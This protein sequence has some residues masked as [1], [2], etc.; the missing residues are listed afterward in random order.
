MPLLDMNLEVYK[1][2]SPESQKKVDCLYRIAI[3][4][5]KAN[6]PPL[7]PDEFDLLYDMPVP[8]VYQKL[9]SARQFYSELAN[10]DGE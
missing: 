1:E 9:Q 4:I 2:L 3:L 10:I 6:H 5:D 8:A 7:T